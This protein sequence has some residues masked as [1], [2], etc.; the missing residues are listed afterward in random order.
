MAFLLH[1]RLKNKGPRAILPVSIVLVDV[2]DHVWRWG[3][4]NQSVAFGNF[5]G[6]KTPIM[7]DLRLLSWSQS[8]LASTES[9]A[10]H[11]IVY[12][13]PKHLCIFLFCLFFFC[14]QTSFS[15]HFQMPQRFIHQRVSQRY[16]FPGRCYLH[17][18]LLHYSLPFQ[19]GM[20]IRITQGLFS[21]EHF[22]TWP[23]FPEFLQNSECEKQSSPV[24]TQ[25]YVQQW[26][27][28][29]GIVS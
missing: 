10:Q 16:I 28:R 3:W 29:A 20:G 25:Q 27:C 15:F 6:V 8:T 23:A 26:R 2:N 13:E 11:S 18:L 7:T 4:G 21:K 1:G 14:F 17:N 9:I 5:C 12:E 22:P 19:G 24:S